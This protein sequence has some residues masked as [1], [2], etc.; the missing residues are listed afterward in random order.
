MVK[1][2][3]VLTRSDAEL[4]VADSGGDGP[5]VVLTHG[6]GMDHTMFDAQ[7]DALTDGGYRVLTWDLRGHGASTLA[8]GTRFR[9]DD[10][11]GDLEA[12]L[13]ECLVDR[14]VMVGHSLGGNLAQAFVRAH[15]Q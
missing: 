8:P 14:A 13:R 4:A 7:F 3:R 1:I 6:A 12:L 10:A 11:L 2:T 9:A 5:A 15:P